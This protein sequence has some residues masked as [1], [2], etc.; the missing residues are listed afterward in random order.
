M[1]RVH[2]V[3]KARKDYPDH[4]IKKGESY[5]WWQFAYGTKRFSKVRPKASQLTQ[6]EFLSNWYSL[7]ESAAATPTE[8]HVGDLK[9]ILEDLKGEVENLRDETQDKL[10]N[11][12]DKFPNGCPS[13]ETLQERV[14]ACERVAEELDGIIDDCDEEVNE[15]GVE[16]LVQRVHELDWSC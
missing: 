1:A 10:S 4:E 12:E 15:N 3:K 13:M 14:D 8:I 5:Y 9:S 2:F 7:E 6:S 11:M 16:E